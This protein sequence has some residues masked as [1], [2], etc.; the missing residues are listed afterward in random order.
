MRPLVTFTVAPVFPQNLGRLGNLY[1]NLYWTWNP[2]I[3]ECLRA[4]SPADWHACNHHPIRML[5]KIS[6]SRLE[7]LAHDPK[8]LAL[9]EAAV[10][11][12]DRYTSAREWYGEARP[13]QEETI[14]Y[15]SAEFGLHESVPL[16]SGGLGVLS[17][18]HTKSA[19]DLGLPFVCI[20][21]MYQMGYFRQRLTTEGEQLESYD[22][23]DPSTLPLQE[24]IDEQRR[25]IRI[26]VDFPL[27]PVTARLWRLDVGR[28]PVYLLDTNVAENAIPE[29]RDI[30][31]YLYG[32]DRETRIMQ[33][34]MLGIG[35]MRALRALGISPTVTHSNEGHSAFLMLER[36]RMLM[37]EMGM[38]FAEAS[39]L[40]AAGSVFTTHTPVPAGNDSF[41][42]ELMDRYFSSYWPQLGL[43]RDEFLGLGR[44]SPSDATE[45]FS[46]TVL[47]LRMTTKR[48]GVSQLHAQVSRAMWSSVWSNVPKPEVPIAGITNGIHTATWLADEMRSLF[49]RY[50]GHD[51]HGRISD[52]DLWT[53]VREIPDEVLWAIKVKLRGE[54]VD[55]VHQR[56]D[57]QQAEWYARRERGR[58]VGEIL[59]PDILTI[60]FAR[61]FATYKRATLL[62]RDPA[63]ALRLFI[64]P[65]R[66]IQLVIA[67]KAHPKDVPGK[68]F[69]RKVIQFIR[70]R[71]L[72]SRIV[73]VEDYDMAVGRRLTQGCDI[74]LNTP[75]RPLEASGT[76]GLKAATN[77][78]LN[79]SIL[80][81]WFP[82]GYDGTNS[83]AIGQG[84]EFNDPDLQDEFES[85]KLYRV[86]EEHVLPAFYDRD[87]HGLPRQ[88]IA[89]QKRSL[90][91]LAGRFSAERMVREYATR[92]Y[93][94][95]SDRYR[96]LAADNGERVRRLVAWKRT[97][98]ER[99]REVR[100]TDV[101][102][103]APSVAPLNGRVRVIARLAVGSLS[104]EEITVEAYEGAID[105]DGL[106]SDGRA[107]PLAFHHTENGVAT[108]GGMIQLD[109]LGHNGLTVRAQPWHP[110]LAGPLEMN[111]LTWAL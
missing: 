91:T 60:G 110:D 107:T 48:N 64:D 106:V 101:N 29:Y 45:D 58:K 47:A 109:R 17:G 2:T 61:R 84:E 86:L 18:D 24:V 44:V 93:F 30:A 98:N 67:G 69:I 53:A 38:T 41:S 56:L 3:R 62:F 72:E 1:T 49:D 65:D 70:E 68:E 15:L 96:G 52:P 22:L 12:L 77:G 20:G 19:S 35:G 78:T 31:D 97:I 7:E 50:L 40:A 99:W 83:F 102:A 81:G 10:A 63:R 85:R 100:F 73:Y 34:I 76:S 43:S 55:Y 6:P 5:Q 88:W 80:D 75:R 46:M 27:G 8:F 111:L 26:S 92:F 105:A 95:S 104:P 36:S 21:L 13:N 90:E 25:P 66:P 23:N 16:Y 32:G 37:H 71:D 28:V 33:E 108:Y 82:E 54:M 14:A 57:E 42:A 79:L 59:S 51:W 11:E 74:W 4:I 103:D 94:P 89:M 9:Y 39:E 87:E